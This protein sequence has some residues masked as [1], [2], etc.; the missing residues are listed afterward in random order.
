MRVL[1]LA[2]KLLGESL[3][4]QLTSEEPELDVIL[5]VEN[6]SGHP[7]L[8]IWSLDSITSLSAIRRQAHDL[9]QQWQPAPLLLL[10]PSDLPFNRDQL[11]ALPAAGLLQNIDTIIL[12]RFRSRIHLHNK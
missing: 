10:L 6:L 5:S 9:Q 7:A 8:V 12:T 3:A 2:P 11:L 1:L 4:L